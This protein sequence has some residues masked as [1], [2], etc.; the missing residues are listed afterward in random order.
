MLRSVDSWGNKNVQIADFLR[1]R[2][3]EL[4]ISQADLAR[5]LT[6]RG[7]STTRATVG[8][9]VAGRNYPPI[10]DRDFRMALA[11]SLEIDVNELMTRIGFAVVDSDR[12][13]EA[14][15]AADIIDRLPSEAKSLALEY[16]D[17]LDRR[18]VTTG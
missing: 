17:M 16:L 14:M 5:R 1:A 3:A 8:H 13:K 15:R 10:E 7:K 9:W 18:Y 6:L 11:A 12:S 2:L 4:D